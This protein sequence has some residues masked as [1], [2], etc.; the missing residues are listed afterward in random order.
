MI[1][2]AFKILIKIKLY[3]KYNKNI[4]KKYVRMILEK[5]IKAILKYFQYSSTLENYLISSKWIAFIVF[6]K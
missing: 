3:K 5:Y 6:L 4:R 2:F 1:T